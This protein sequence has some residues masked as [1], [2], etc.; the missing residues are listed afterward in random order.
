MFPFD[1][2]IFLRKGSRDIKKNSEGQGLKIGLFC[3]GCA[4]LLH[5][6]VD[7]SFYFSQVSFFWWIILGLFA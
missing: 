4:F 2:I 3:G 7:L 1:Y 5:N 6:L